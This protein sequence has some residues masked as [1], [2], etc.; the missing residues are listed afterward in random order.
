MIQIQN[1]LFDIMYDIS[2]LTNQSISFYK[3]QCKNLKL[4]EGEY[5]IYIDY[6]IVSLRYGFN[7]SM[8]D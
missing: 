4:Q 8:S 5:D 1:K 6:L 3:G 7:L 2:L